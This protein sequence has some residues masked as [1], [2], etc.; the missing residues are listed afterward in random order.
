MQL[1]AEDEYQQ[2]EQKTKCVFFKPLNKNIWQVFLYFCVNNEFGYSLQRIL[3]F[4]L[5]SALVARTF[6]AKENIKPLARFL[7]TCFSK[8]L[9]KFQRDLIS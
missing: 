7:E 5:S 8:T 3:F 4:S 6:K 9:V 2:T 1:F